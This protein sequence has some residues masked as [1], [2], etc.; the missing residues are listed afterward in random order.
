[1]P[2]GGTLQL[3]A[4][5]TENEAVIAVAD[6]GKGI[7]EEIKPRLFTPLVT[8]KAKGQGLGLAVVKR[9][10]EALGGSIK[11]ESELGKG[12]TFTITLP[13]REKRE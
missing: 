7:P 13:L 12:T 8:T 6:T 4:L 2:D 11:F 10:V 5:K 3:T 1:M 9:L